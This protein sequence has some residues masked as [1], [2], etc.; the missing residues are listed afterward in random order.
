[1]EK[2]E[3][4]RSL[5]APRNFL[6]IFLL[7]ALLGS[8]YAWAGAAPGRDGEAASP[9]PGPVLEV[10][11]QENLEKPATAA[12]SFTL[13]PF[14]LIE[15]EASRVRVRRVQVVLEFLQPDILPKFD[16]RSPGLRELVY[17]FL[18]GKEQG[19]PGRERKEQEKLL[20]GLVN[21]YLGQE[22]VSAVKVDQSFLLLR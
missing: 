15:E 4:G 7:L 21:R 3:M 14:F 19:Y 16:P 10:K 20:T 8:E 18:V 17:D 9:K 6:G 11:I 1:M 12:S 5:A 22:A 13:D 2:S